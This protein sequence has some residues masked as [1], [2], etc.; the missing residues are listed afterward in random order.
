MVHNESWF[1]YNKIVVSHSC[2][3]GSS[4]KD[5]SSTS[6]PWN[7]VL[8]MRNTSILYTGVMSSLALSIV[9]SS[10]SGV[11]SPKGPL[12]DVTLGLHVCFSPIL[13]ADGV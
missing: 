8:F 2:C 5:G 6:L 1:D 13:T 11:H 4:H 12:V 10:I 3:G 7:K 9:K